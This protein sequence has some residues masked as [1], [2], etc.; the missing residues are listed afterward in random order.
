M[1]VI[2]F[3]G[4]QPAMFKNIVNLLKNKHITLYSVVKHQ[5][6]LENQLQPEWVDKIRL[7][8][9]PSP[10]FKTDQNIAL[11]QTQNS[12]VKNSVH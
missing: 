2:I 9:V 11:A 7:S 5:Q 8:H 4:E 3:Y 1:N 12:N 6:Y 10:Q